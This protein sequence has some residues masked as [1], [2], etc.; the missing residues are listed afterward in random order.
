MRSS[1]G[2]W[3]VFAEGRIGAEAALA[4][5]C[6]KRWQRSVRARANACFLKGFVISLCAENPIRAT[7]SPASVMVPGLQ[8]EFALTHGCL[9]SDPIGLRLVLFWPPPCEESCGLQRFIRANVSV[10]SLWVVLTLGWCGIGSAGDAF[11]FAL[12]GEQ[13]Q[14]LPLAWLRLCRASRKA[15]Q[16]IPREYNCCFWPAH[17]VWRVSRSMDA[18]LNLQTANNQSSEAV[19]SEI[20]NRC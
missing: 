4:R 14:H 6:R 9:E 18:I 7:A 20:A 8:I 17:G 5:L 10:S 16:P 15:S 3:L 13:G 12:D 2:L 1:L 19:R 11:S